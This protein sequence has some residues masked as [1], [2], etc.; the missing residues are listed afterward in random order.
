MVKHKFFSIALS[1]VSVISLIAILSGCNGSG[2][3]NPATATGLADIA[4][5]QAP[6]TT[7]LTTATTSCININNGQDCIIFVTPD[8]HNGDMNNSDGNNSNGR[9]A[10]DAWCNSQASTYYPE[11]VSESIT[12]KALLAFNT[13]TTVGRTYYQIY[14]NGQHDT[15]TRVPIAVA[16]NGNLAHYLQ[17]PIMPSFNHVNYEIWTGLNTY[18]SEYNYKQSCDNWTDQYH[19]NTTFYGKVSHTWLAGSSWVDGTTHNCKEQYH[20]ACVAQ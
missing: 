4:K 6:V 12:F 1:R 10:A 20:L 13:A 2:G 5:V 19:G 3:A 14:P 17:N 8:T 11:L 16:T 9:A 18:T 15:T 7:I